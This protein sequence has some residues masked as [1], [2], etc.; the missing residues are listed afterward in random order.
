MIPNVVGAMAT[1]PVLI[2]SLVG[3]FQ[4][5]HGGDFSEEQI[6]V[7]LLTNAVTNSCSWAVTFHT[8][9]ALKEC[10]YPAD[11]ETEVLHAK[12]LAAPSA[13]H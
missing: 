7:L 5:V 9:L 3:L 6:Q 1:S 2:A 11:D 13:V 10:M 12:L 8:F 4:K